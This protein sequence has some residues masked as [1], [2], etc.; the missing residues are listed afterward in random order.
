MQEQSDSV[1]DQC[2]QCLVTSSIGHVTRGNIFFQLV[3]K[4]NANAKRHSTASYKRLATR[5]CKKY[6]FVQFSLQFA[7][8]FS[9]P[10]TLYRCN[11]DS[12][13]CNLLRN[14]VAL[15][16]ARKHASCNRILAILLTTLWQ[17]Y[18]AQLY[19]SS[20]NYNVCA[21][22]TTIAADGA[23]CSIT[24][25]F[26]L[27]SQHSLCHHGFGNPTALTGPHICK[28]KYTFMIR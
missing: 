28:N 22:G 6:E 2:G 15:Q 3:V 9:L 11:T 25:L 1:T 19:D 14:R 18:K 7:S 24:R 20:D 13:F 5:C 8:R 17:Q 4:C 16:I 10:S 26:A 27:L 23:N 12:F 21:G